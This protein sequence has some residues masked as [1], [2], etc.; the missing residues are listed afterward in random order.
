M[1]AKRSLSHSQYEQ[2]LHTLTHPP[3][4]RRSPRPHIHT[5]THHT[6]ETHATDQEDEEQEEEQQ[7]QEEEREEAGQS[8]GKRNAMGQ[9]R[10]DET[11]HQRH[12][13]HNPRRRGTIAKVSGEEQGASQTKKETDAGAQPKKREDRRE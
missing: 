6:Q 10:G 4:E 8:A 12:T 9:Q 7:E 2:L 13:K 1:P 3:D 5:S 11:T